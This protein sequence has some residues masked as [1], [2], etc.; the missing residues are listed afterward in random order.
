MIHEFKYFVILVITGGLL[1][2]IS[3]D[4]EENEFSQPVIDCLIDK[5]SV[6]VGNEMIEIG[7]RKEFE[8][9][10]EVIYKLSVVSSRD[11]AKFIV[12]SSSDAFSKDSRVLKTVPADVIDEE[13]NFIK[14][15]KKWIFIMFTIF[16]RLFR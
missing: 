11:L 5:V 9:D 15:V 3:C 13:G 7:P 1:S 16:I 14:A 4:D 6:E 2:F 8:Q 12:S 10:S